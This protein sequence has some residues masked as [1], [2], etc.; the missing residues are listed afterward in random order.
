MRWRELEE[1][2]L[3]DRLLD[4]VHRNAQRFR[5]PRYCQRIMGFSHDGYEVARVRK[6]RIK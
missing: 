5:P 6:P 2:G 3:S 4:A 1:Q